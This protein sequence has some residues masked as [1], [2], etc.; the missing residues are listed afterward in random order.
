MGPLAGVSSEFSGPLLTVTNTTFSGN[1]GSDAGAIYDYGD[2]AAISG[3]TFT[4]NS[5]AIGAGALIVDLGGYTEVNNSTLTGNTGGY[6]GAVF[7][8]DES[9]VQILGSTLN[10]NVS[11]GS[12]TSGPPILDGGGLLAIDGYAV[13]G[14]DTFYNNSSTSSQGVG[15]ISDMGEEGGFVAGFNITVTGNSGFIGAMVDDSGGLQSDLE[16]SIASGNTTTDPN[17]TSDNITPDSNGMALNGGDVVNSPGISLSGLGNYSGATQTI[18]PLPASTAICA[19]S[20]TGLTNAFSNYDLQLTTDQRGDPNTNSTYPFTGG[21]CV[22]AGA[23]QTNYAIGFTTQ[24]AN[25]VAGLAMSPAPV[26]T[27]TESGTVFTAGPGTIRIGDADADLNGSSTLSLSTTSGTAG[28]GRLLFI[29]A[30]TGDKLTATLALNPAISATSPAISSVSN[31]FNVVQP[32]PPFGHLDVSVDSVTGST[33]VGQSD[34]LV[35]KGW[36]AVE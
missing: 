5:A 8:V 33:T 20:V 25:A 32:G 19:G 29:S 16:N 27:L 28:F 22:D 17:A 6:A 21:T 9:E 4:N 15:A 10:D 11:S 7:S 36:V 35:V 30:K 2:Q 24:P 14:Y 26:V 3:A 1:I 31:S 13:L 18:I 23:V 12:G 34:S